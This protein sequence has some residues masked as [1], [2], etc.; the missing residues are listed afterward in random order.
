[1]RLEEFK[2]ELYVF[3]D[4]SAGSM[5]RFYRVARG[6]NSAWKMLRTDE[7]IKSNTAATREEAQEKLAKY[8]S[9]TA[10]EKYVKDQEKQAAFAERT[11]E[12]RIR[13]TERKGRKA[14]PSK[15]DKKFIKYWKGRLRYHRSN[16]SKAPAKFEDLSN[17]VSIRKI[18][19]TMT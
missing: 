2:R 11:A 10:G 4:E 6:A 8:L 16:I 12:R 14:F 1:M 3:Y 19:T 5:V 17:R 9:L 7:P 18:T 15:E 13:E